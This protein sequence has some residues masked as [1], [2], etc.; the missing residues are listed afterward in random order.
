MQ[1]EM[2]PS[3]VEEPSGPKTISVNP[4]KLMYPQDGISAWFSCGR[5]VMEAVE[6]LRSGEVCVE[7]FPPIKVVQYRGELWSMDNRRLFA[8]KEAGITE[9]EAELCSRRNI[10]STA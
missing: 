9:V 10:F 7:D 4:Q 2:L 6:Q 8:F 3:F 5:S 1:R